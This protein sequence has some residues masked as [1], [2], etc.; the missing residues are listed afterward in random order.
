MEYGFF[1]FNTGPLSNAGAIERVVVSAEQL[2]YESVWSAEHLVMMDP[3][4]PVLPVP[5]KSNLVGSIASLAFAAAK[6]ERIRIGSGIILIALRDPIMLAKEL[7]AVDVLS[8]GR[9]LAGFGVGF[10]PREFETLGIPFEERGARTSEHI[11]VLRTLWTEEQPAFDGQFTKFSGVQSRP[12][13]VQKPHP[14]IILGGDSPP[15]LRRAVAQADGWYSFHDVE[16]TAQ[17][18]KALEE[19]A[20]TTERP[21][22]LGRLNI[23]VSPFGPIDADTAKRYEDLGVDRLVLVR[24]SFETSIP[25]SREAEDTIVRFLEDQAR[26]IGIG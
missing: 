12:L 16:G 20:K 11:E 15:A 23:I 1:G 6:T 19:A 26:D 5:P 7:A 8:G 2:G 21:A 25:P 9:L 10:V 24:D 4:D 22:S 3:E 13:P 18:L 14:P 17:M